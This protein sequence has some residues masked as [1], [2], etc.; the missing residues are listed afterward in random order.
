MYVP[1]L[2]R[3]K[4]LACLLAAAVAIA[5][6]SM[7]PPAARA[8]TTYISVGTSTYST[9]SNINLQGQVIPA[10]CTFISQYEGLFVGHQMSSRESWY[11]D[12]S[13]SDIRC[14]ANQSTGFGDAEVGF[15]EG[16]SGPSHPQLFSV[17]VAISAPT[18]YSITT[19]LRL[20]YGR[21]GAYL[22]TQLF[23]SW[24]LDPRHTGYVTASIG[25]KGYTGYP[26]PQLSTNVGAGLNV[27]PGAQ[28]QFAY[29]G[30]TA[31]GAGG[32]D[33]DFGVNPQHP[34]RYYS[35]QY[36]PAVQFSLSPHSG[37]NLNAWKLI[38]GYNV[39]IGTS[40]SANYFVHF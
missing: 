19:P 29:W 7:L 32:S 8:D 28:L 4:K 18:G 33:A 13:H 16:I 9:S 26:A 31:I 39:G 3:L 2:A 25:V 14:G 24:S 35:Y 12:T 34:A 17:K 21:P 38:G 6:V 20:G 11:A 22:G 27:T 40:L 36:V 30:S 10:Y 23:T 5:V 15:Q 37:I 1:H